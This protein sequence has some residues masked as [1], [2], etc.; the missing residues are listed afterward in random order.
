MI[1]LRKTPLQIKAKT[2]IIGEDFPW[3]NG[4]EIAF[5]FPDMEGNKRSIQPGSIS[6]LIKHLMNKP[7]GINISI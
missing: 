3:H 1:E 6:L 4:L 7:V 5:I 2:L